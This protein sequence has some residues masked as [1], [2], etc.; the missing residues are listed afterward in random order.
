MKR[1]PITTLT[2]RLLTK[3]PPAKW[4]KM[5]D[6]MDDEIR[7]QVQNTLCDFAERAAYLNSYLG[8]F[9]ERHDAKAAQRATV[10]VRRILGYSYPEDCPLATFTPDVA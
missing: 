3:T 1:D 7:Q 10:R 6:G 9:A 2:V 5:L 4:R 8:G